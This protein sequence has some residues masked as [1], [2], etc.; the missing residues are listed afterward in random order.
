MYNVGIE[1]ELVILF[2][3]WHETAIFDGW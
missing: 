1:L 3:T 2:F